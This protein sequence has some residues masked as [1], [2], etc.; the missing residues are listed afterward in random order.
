MSISVLVC[1]H[2]HN[3]DPLLNTIPA[4]LIKKI[5]FHGAS[6]QHKR[7]NKWI[8]FNIVILAV[9][10]PSAMQ[11]L[12]RKAPTMDIF[13]VVYHTGLLWG[14]QDNRAA[15]RFSSLTVEKSLQHA[16]NF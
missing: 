10:M 3:P 4:N 8:S 9:K 15:Q 14:E 2:T 13:C 16:K 7:R 12:F 1:K 11:K 6:V 5:R